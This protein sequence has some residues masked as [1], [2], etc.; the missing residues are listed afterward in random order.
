MLSFGSHTLT[1]GDSHSPLTSSTN[2]W[3]LGYPLRLEI[4][5]QERGLGRW[6]GDPFVLSVNKTL[7]A[8]PTAWHSGE[9]SNTELGAVRRDSKEADLFQLAENL[10]LQALGDVSCSPRQDSW[11]GMGEVVDLHRTKGLTG[12]AA[13][14]THLTCCVRAPCLSVRLPP[15][16]KSHSVP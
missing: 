2:G 15:A 8:L 7:Y 1:P 12:T 14:R 13:T 9:H 16:P 6:E 4:A 5:C 10:Q 3:L 11:L